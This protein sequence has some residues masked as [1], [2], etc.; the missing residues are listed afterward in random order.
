VDGLSLFR[1][2][3]VPDEYLQVAGNSRI[4]DKF[5]AELLRIILFDFCHDLIDVPSIALSTAELDFHLEA[6][7]PGYS[8]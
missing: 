3:S 7:D 6:F 1:V 5:E 8:I 2:R 4:S